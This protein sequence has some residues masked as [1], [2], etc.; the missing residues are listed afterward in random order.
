[1]WYWLEV[2]NGQDLPDSLMSARLKY[3][4][5]DGQ[6]SSHLK[7]YSQLL[8]LGEQLS[9]DLMSYETVITVSESDRTS[10]VDHV[11][12]VMMDLRSFLPGMEE[13][14]DHLK[15][16]LEKCLE[17]QN[18]KKAGVEVRMCPLLCL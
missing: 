2:E 13:A 7:Q 1:M 15:E 9:T 18:L 6:R 14:M 10:G 5:F 8:A 3:D 17:L 12:G 4:T 11:Q 16:R